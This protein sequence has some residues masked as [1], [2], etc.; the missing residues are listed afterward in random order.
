MNPA[1]QEPLVE[2]SEQALLNRSRQQDTNAYAELIRLYHGKIY[3][4]IY[5]M[6]ANREDAEDLA[7]DVFI[8]AY[9]SLPRFKGESS[10]YT[11]IYRIAINRT[12]NFLK[13]RSRKAAI[14]L[15]D[16]DLA[17]ERDPAYV[18]LSS[19]SNPAKDFT[20]TE[21]REKL[22]IA[23]LVLSDKHRAVIVMHD[24]QGMPH[25]E[26]AEVLG[27]SSGT[28]RSRIFYARQCLQRE[29]GD[30]LS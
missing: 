4:M 10:F 17:I 30:Y 18:A 9:D 26:I 11:W 6:T 21:L 20:L 22:N 1:L 3:G 29:L 5:N 7:Q 16:V 25:E 23:L 19:K 14:S 8:K 12:L 2:E 27:C 15:D 13:K 28:V 24:I